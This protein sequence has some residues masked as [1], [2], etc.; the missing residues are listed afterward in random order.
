CASR[1]LVE[2]VRKGLTGKRAEVTVQDG[3]V[4][5]QRPGDREI[6]D[7]LG[8]MIF[9]VVGV[10][11]GREGVGGGQRNAGVGSR[12]SGPLQE[13]VHLAE[14]VLDQEAFPA[15]VGVAV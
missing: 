1:V 8:P 6:G 2:T 10:V 3:V 7:S 12:G 4:L 9:V 15:V 5:S 13:A 11:T 14:V